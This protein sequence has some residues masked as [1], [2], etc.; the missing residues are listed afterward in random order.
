MVS[1]SRFNLHNREQ[2]IALFTL[3]EFTTIRVR[4]ADMDAVKSPTP[5][6]QVKPKHPVIPVH[7]NLFG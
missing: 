6:L 3:F 7:Y 1:G 2:G 4:I 5:K